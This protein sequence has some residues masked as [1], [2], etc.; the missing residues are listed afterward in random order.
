MNTIDFQSMMQMQAM[1]TLQGERQGGKSFG[2]G[3]QQMM[4]Q[5]ILEASMNNLTQAPEKAQNLTSVQ[6]FSGAQAPAITDVSSPIQREDSDIDG[7][8]REASEKFGVQENLI[9]SVIQ[10]E[11]NFNPEAVSHAGA[12]GLM[13]LMP[14]TAEGL[15]VKDPMNP[16]ENVMGGTM[17]LRDMLS[18]YD[19]NEQLALAAYNAGPGNVDKHGGIPPFEETQNYVRKVLGTA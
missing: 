7:I 10:A 15:G 18:R 9:R 6:V 16:K 14:G 2:S 1:R 13:Q 5:S 19:G 3:M 4:F 12:Q 11:S 17:Y 8:I